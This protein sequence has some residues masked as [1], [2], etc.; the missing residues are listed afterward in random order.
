MRSTSTLGGKFRDWWLSTTIVFMC[1][2]HSSRQLLTQAHS[3]PLTQAV[4]CLSLC[5]SRF[6]CLHPHGTS[7]RTAGLLSLP[8]GPTPC[9]SHHLAGTLS[10]SRLLAVRPHNEQA[11][12]C[13]RNGHCKSP[14][15]KISAVPRIVLPLCPTRRRHPPW[16]AT[17]HSPSPHTARVHTPH[18]HLLTS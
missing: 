12:S 14:T 7:I 8:I 3:Y 5:H 15:P 6:H 2:C 4:D 13:D 10:R 11:C 16:F 9:R 17:H 1:V 18:I